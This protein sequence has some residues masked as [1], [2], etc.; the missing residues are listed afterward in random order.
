MAWLII[1]QHTD[2]CYGGHLKFQVTNKTSDNHEILFV[3]S[4]SIDLVGI[5]TL[6]IFLE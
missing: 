1:R 5:D 2:C 3:Q 6:I 4:E